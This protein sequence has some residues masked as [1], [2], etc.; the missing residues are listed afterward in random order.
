MAGREDFATNANVIQAASMDH[1]ISHGNVTALVDGVVCS[2]TRI[3]T[4]VQTTGLVEME[5]HATIQDKGN[6]HAHANQDGK[7]KIV[8][9][10]SPTNANINH[11][12]MVE[13]ARYI[14]AHHISK[15]K[16]ESK[17]LMI[18]VEPC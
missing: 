16:N 18:R 2:V 12:S 14:K 6:I 3:W 15:D 5:P 9:F 13:H 8:K 4:T 7:G 11:A 1:A 17:T 10:E